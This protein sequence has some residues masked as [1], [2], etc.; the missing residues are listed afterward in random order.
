MDKIIHKILD[1]TTDVARFHLGITD[2]IIE[3]CLRYLTRQTIDNIDKKLG[4]KIVAWHVFVSFPILF[5][6]FI[7]HVYDFFSVF[8]NRV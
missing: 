5:I 6:L 1:L 7:F 3:S 4:F 2:Y 8:L